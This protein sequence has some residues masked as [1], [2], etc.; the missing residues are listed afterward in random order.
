MKIAMIS[1]NTFLPGE[2]NGWKNGKENDILLLQGETVN[3]SQS[4]YARNQEMIKGILKDQSGGINNLNELDFIVI[5]LGRSG[6]EHSIGLMKENNVSPEKLIFVVCECELPLKK[7][8]L[9]KSGYGNS[10]LAMSECGGFR[11]MMGLYRD[12][13]C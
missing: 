4:N 1:Y 2:K 6:A 13:G 3:F 8:L 7:D 11:E 9:K 12:L 10:I 5:Y